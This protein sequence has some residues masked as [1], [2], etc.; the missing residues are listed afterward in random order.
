MT[1]DK[2]NSFIKNFNKWTERVKTQNTLKNSHHCYNSPQPH[3]SSPIKSYQLGH[4]Y[5]ISIKILLEIEENP[6]VTIEQPELVLM[7]SLQRLGTHVTQTL[8]WQYYGAP[9]VII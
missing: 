2:D 8:T 5:K 7:P 1:L 6:F 4:T 3:I 9:K